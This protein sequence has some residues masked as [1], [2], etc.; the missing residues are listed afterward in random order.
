[1]DNRN[2]IDKIIELTIEEIR[3]RMERQVNLVKSEVKYSSM[4]AL[5]GN[6]YLNYDVDTADGGSSIF[7]GIQAL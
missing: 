2:R 5:P 6:C 3:F 1:M 4:P 7:S